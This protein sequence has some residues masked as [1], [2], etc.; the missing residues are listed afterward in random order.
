[1]RAIPGSKAHLGGIDGGGPI[2]EAGGLVRE[3]LCVY[4]HERLVAWPRKMAE[5]RQRNEFL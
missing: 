4:E 5:G 1:M 3:K 2:V